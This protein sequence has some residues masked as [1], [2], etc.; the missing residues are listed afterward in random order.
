MAICTEASL[1]SVHS[2]QSLLSRR[3]RRSHAKSVQYL[4]EDNPNHL[5]QSLHLNALNAAIKPNP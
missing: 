5:P 3:H 1:L 2:S 4:A